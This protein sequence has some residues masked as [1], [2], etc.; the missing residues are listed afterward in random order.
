VNTSYLQINF[1]G[2][3]QEWPLVHTV[4]IAT[5]G[6]HD[7]N[8]S[9]YGDAIGTPVSPFGSF[10]LDHA[11]ITNAT[12]DGADFTHFIG[13]ALTVT[14]S[15]FSGNMGGNIKS[16]PEA[17]ILVYNNTVVTNCIRLQYAYPGAQAGYNSNLSDFCRSAGDG[18]G[19]S[20]L[21]TAQYIG[22]AYAVGTAVTGVGTHFTTQVSVG[23]VVAPADFSFSTYGGITV[24]SITDDT[25]LVVSGAYPTNWGTSGDPLH[26]LYIPGGTPSSSSVDTWYHNSIVGYAAT[27]INAGCLF[28]LQA[29]GGYASGL[30]D[31]SYC[32]GYTFTFKDNGILGYVDSNC[33]IGGCGSGTTPPEMWAGPLPTAQDYNVFYNL[34]TCPSVGGHDTCSQNMAFVSQPTSPIGI[35]NESVLD[36]YNFTLTSAG[37]TTLGVTIAGQTTDQIGRAWA[38]PPSIGAL[39]YVSSGNPVVIGGSVVFGGVGVIQ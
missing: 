7:D 18:N 17:N 16:G 2:C 1:A 6:C 10:T 3:K 14:N 28:G 27:T 12:Q 11:S 34:T 32:A 21:T 5:G 33:T 4:P 29:G 30:A 22:N 35:G 36:A 24:A 15:T 26:F 9:G 25:H 13:G 37:P 23:N 31:V 8:S 39:Q 19:N 20:I 38:S